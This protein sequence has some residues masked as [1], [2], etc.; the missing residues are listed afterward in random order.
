MRESPKRALSVHAFSLISVMVAM[1]I[2]GLSVTAIMTL[3]ASSTKA[4]VEAVRMSTG[5]RL[6]TNIH[7]YALTLNHNFT[8]STT[9]TTL[10]SFLPGH[11]YSTVIDSSGQAI[12][13]SSFS[14]WTQYLK[15]TPLNP[16]TL[17]PVTVTDDGDW[18][19]RPKLLLVEVSRNGAVVYSQSWILAPALQS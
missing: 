18:G 11:T 17:Q 8:V 5:I 13:D 6:A 2:V 10:H 12:T 3:L 4:N 19:W 16:T 14:G 7:E 1:V 9:G 15:V